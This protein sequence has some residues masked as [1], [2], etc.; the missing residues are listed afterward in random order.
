MI[1]EK[2]KDIARQLILINP[3]YAKTEEV[4]LETIAQI[5]QAFAEDGYVLA[6]EK[7]LSRLTGEMAKILRKGGL[8]TGQEWYDRFGNALFDYIVVD[9]ENHMVR[10]VD[11]RKAAKKA[12]RL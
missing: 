11:I 1:D 12:A 10:L 5:K 9:E 8:I 2:L 6:D 7:Y 3:H 4:V